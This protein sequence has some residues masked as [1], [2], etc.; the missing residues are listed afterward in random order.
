MDVERLKAPIQQGKMPAAD[1]LAAHARAVMVVYQTLQAEAE[2]TA[3]KHGIKNELVRKF[4]PLGT[5]IDVQAAIATG[6]ASG[7]GLRINPDTIS[8]I[9]QA[10]A[11]QYRNASE[12]LAQDGHG[13]RVFAWNGKLVRQDEEGSPEADPKLLRKWLRHTFDDFR[14]QQNGLLRKR[15]AYELAANGYQIVAI[16]DDEFILEATPKHDVMAVESVVVSAA[17]TVLGNIA[18]HCCNCQ[19]AD[20]W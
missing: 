15:I 16:T 11:A 17:S 12:T 1:D 9:E 7:A 4:G 3:R 14:D 6:A 8:Q 2:Q 10:A 19:V 18:Q 5:G 20:A 13:R